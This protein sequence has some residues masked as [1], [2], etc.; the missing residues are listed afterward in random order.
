MKEYWVKDLGLAGKGRKRIEWSRN[1][2][3]VL[4]KISERFERE[5][6]LKGVRIGA[7]LH[8]TTETAILAEA[9]VKGGAEVSLCASNPLSTQDDVAAA[10]AEEGIR[11]YAF[12][13]ETVEEYYRCLGYV[14]A[15]EP[16]LTIDDGADLISA[17]HKLYYGIESKE[18]GYV[19]E[20]AGSIDV[21]NLVGEMLGGS[22]ETT[23]G[24]MRLRA[25]ARE[26]KLLYP[27]IAVNDA[28]SKSLFDNPIGSGQ[29]ALDGVIRATGALLAGREAV[30]VG[31]GNVG[32]GI[33]RRLRGMGARVTVVEVDPIKAL[34]ALMEGFNVEPMREA[35]KHGD[36][37]ITA[38]GNI[39]VIRREHFEVMKDGAILA[40]SGH[41]DVEINKRDL[42]QLSVRK[43][44]ITP[45]I[46]MYVLKDGR[47]LYLL[48][49][50]R[51]VNLVCAEGHPCDVMDMSFSLQALSAEH[52]AKNRGKLP[53][54][55]LD[56]PR[57]IDE[58]VARLKLESMGAAVEELTPEQIRY[59][60]QWETGSE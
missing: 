17:I 27:V 16:N 34:R 56:V 54:E 11:I 21:R 18:L 22:E 31:Y 5:K 7:C 43:E 36:L 3:P 57:E 20:A 38:T 30:V 13:G 47:R 6:P 23:T 51:L 37:F 44:R 26:G 46:D 49:E 59:L 15:S 2:M 58:L 32:S 9:L 8:I 42:E 28:E 52:I 19:R 10:I 41:F 35:A 40:N 24:V 1:L 45:C 48:G 55:V 29:S 53:V 14:L 4:S 60:S 50:G 39:S 33:A 25:M 12:R